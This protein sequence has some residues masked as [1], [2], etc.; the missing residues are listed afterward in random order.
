MNETCRKPF[1]KSV[2]PFS[3]NYDPRIGRF[4]VQDPIGLAGGNLNLYHYT[5]NPLVW[6]DPMGLALS[7]VDF[8]GILSIYLLAGH[9]E[10]SLKSHFKDQGGEIS[11]KP[12]N[13]QA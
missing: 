13:L 11:Q 1:N 10:I 3:R 9:N 4:I 2:C 7:G 12:T 5:P 6:I 8:S